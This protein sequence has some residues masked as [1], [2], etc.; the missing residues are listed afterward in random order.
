MP[1]NPSTSWSGQTVRGQFSPVLISALVALLYAGGHLLWYLS[2]PLGQVPV[3]D[4][5]EN[6]VLV[7]QIAHGGLPAEPFYRA[8]GYALILAGVRSLG[9]SSTA[10][11]PAA[12]VLGLLFQAVNAGIVARIS[13]KLFGQG[14]A[15]W[16]GLLTAGYPVL[17]H[18]STQA[19]DA[20]PALTFFLLGLDRLI[21]P[22]D[23][24]I[25]PSDWVVSSICWAAATLMRPNY[26]AV[27]LLLPVI[28][29][30]VTA[31]TPRWKN[32]CTAVAGA[33]LF[34]AASLWQWSVS[35][36]AGF[37]PWQGAYNLW[38]ANQPSGHGRY[39]VQKTI[40]P[41]ALA[42]QNPA[43]IE[44]ILFYQQA[45]HHTDTAIPAMNAYWRSQFFEEI[46]SEPAR[47]AGL[48][49]RKVYAFCN[50][51]EQY[52]NKTYAFHRARSPW[53]CWNPL[54]F[55]IILILGTAG[56]FRLAGENRRN[57]GILLAAGCVYAGSVLLFYVSDRF[58][59]PI[60]PLAIA[61]SAGAL[62]S[63]SFWRAWAS[64]KKWALGSCMVGV[65]V[66]TFSNF[67]QVRS[68]ATFVQDHALLAR[69]AETV[70]DDVLAWDEARAA[71][72]LQPQHPDAQR[73]AIAAYFNQLV[74]ETE[75]RAGEAEWLRLSREFL[76]RPTPAGAPTEL[77]AV[78]ALALWRAGERDAAFTEWRHLPESPSALGAR[79]LARDNSA[80][81]TDLDA[82]SANAHLPPLALLAAIHENRPWAKAASGNFRNPEKLAAQLFVSEKS[83]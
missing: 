74:N 41:A 78:A 54:S 43:R 10:I 34:I 51:W 50:D 81:S 25:R 46:K 63:P 80:N 15:W 24:S 9:V 56:A 22:P 38:A 4:E 30:L 77:R 11:F 16:G 2:T 32:S 44:S 12:L 49:A 40:L 76:A 23:D 36:V 75:T 66:L 13:G 18:F 62:A 48:L 26:F 7:E 57:G 68:Q 39:Y 64:R 52:N 82:F 1:P 21:K 65:A 31:T 83:P 59:L 29:A 42:R 79:L 67:D 58:R 8:P 33:G 55:G 3:L 20:V 14:A 45:T 47:W 60:A 71:L 72:A 70:G 5:Q 61:L 17:I 73:I 69:A 53:L 19:L 27:W 37:L 6:L 28:A 35:G